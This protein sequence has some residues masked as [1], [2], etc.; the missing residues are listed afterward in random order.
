MSLRALITATPIRNPLPYIIAAL[1]FGAAM[2]AW[3]SSPAAAQGPTDV[4]PTPPATVDA[5]NPRIVVTSPAADAALNSPVVVTGQA[6]VFEANVVITI[7]NAE[8]EVLVETFTTALGAGPDLHPFQSDPI[9]F[10]VSSTQAGCVWVAESPGDETVA[11]Q[12]VAIPV[13]LVAAGSGEF[14]IVPDPGGVTITIYTGTLAQLQVSGAAL[15]LV[16]CFATEGGQF[17]GLIFNAPVFVN[18]AFTTQY[19]AGFVSHPLV[20]RRA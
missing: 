13:T 5:D 10:S 16:S 6:G 20:C 15:D 19:E 12:T 8:G 11:A 1:L 7:F 3:P 18:A 14:T 4:C 17:I 2:A 9:A